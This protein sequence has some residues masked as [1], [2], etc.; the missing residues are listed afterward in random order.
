MMGQMALV[1]GCGSAIGEAIARRLVASGARVVVSDRPGVELGHLGMEAVGADLAVPGECERLVG[2]V[3]RRLGGINVLVN[4]AALTTRSDLESTDAEMFD[5]IM[6]VNAR[7]PLLLVRAAV[8][9]MKEAGGGRVLNIGS[10]NAYCGEP[11]LLAYSMSKGALMTM[12]RNLADALGRERILVNQMNLGW[13][14][15][16]GERRVKREEGWAE[17]WPERVPG[18]FAPSGRLLS[19]EEVAHFAMG[20]VGEGNERVSGTVCDLEQYPVVGRNPAK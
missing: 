20:F 19:P 15:T 2:E 4:N 12:T 5:R 1:T 16:P 14:L 6:A 11:N 17:D 8:G 7:G 13:V 9:H 10:I 3:V 18:A